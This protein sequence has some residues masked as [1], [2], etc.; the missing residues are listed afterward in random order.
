MHYGIPYTSGY[1]IVI[2]NAYGKANESAI[3]LSFLVMLL[4]P[5]GQGTGVLIA[6]CPEGQVP[7]YVFR[8]WGS[9]YGGRHYTPRKKGFISPFMKR[10][11]VLNPSPDKT[12]L[13]LLC[14]N[15]DAEVVKTWPEVLAKL[16]E[17]YPG[18]AKV[19]VVPDGTIQYL[20]PP[21]K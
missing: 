20:M 4:K 11:V 3:A 17:Q 2:S 12:F 15:D 13:D 16:Q 6:D 7:H 8:A 1:D 19:A 18:E 14:H 5:G 10:L 9:E 21:V